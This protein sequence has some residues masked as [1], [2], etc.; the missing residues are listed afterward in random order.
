MVSHRKSRIRLESLQTKI[1]AMATAADPQQKS[2]LPTASPENLPIAHHKIFNSK[3]RSEWFGFYSDIIYH[4][5]SV[6]SLRPGPTPVATSKRLH[7]LLDFP[8]I[9]MRFSGTCNTADHRRQ[10]QIQIFFLKKIEVGP[11]QLSR[12]LRGD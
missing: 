11:V 2:S 6:S 5:C 8:E 1:L 12:C 3:L 9:F 10:R 4:D 7:F